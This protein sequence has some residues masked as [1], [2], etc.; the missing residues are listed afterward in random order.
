MIGE[1]MVK[2]EAHLAVAGDRGE[3]TCPTGRR[4]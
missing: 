2:G 1:R 4:F 3:A